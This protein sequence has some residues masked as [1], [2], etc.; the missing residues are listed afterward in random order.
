MKTTRTKMKM[1]GIKM[2]KY[3]LAG[4]TGASDFEERQRRKKERARTK[5][6][7]AAIEGEGT[8]SNKRNNRAERISLV[9]GTKRVKVPKRLSTSTSSSTSNTDNSNSGNTSNITS[10]GSS[11][12]AVAGA[13]ADA[14]AKSSSTITPMPRRTPG[15]ITPRP[16]PDIRKG[17][18][19][20]PK[21]N[22]PKQKRGGSTKAIKP[23]MKVG[24]AT[25]KKYF[26]GGPTGDGAGTS[27]KPTTTPEDPKGYV[28][29]KLK[30]AKYGTAMMRKGGVIKSKKK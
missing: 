29:A 1:G 20:T 6:E 13:N 25:P 8:V 11:S 18:P 19:N 21:P 16:L 9:I 4:A 28:K 10:S 27:R 26:S 23:K 2:K 3:E 12:G 14:G 24:G 7:V 5:A 22:T 15:K 17:K 30:T